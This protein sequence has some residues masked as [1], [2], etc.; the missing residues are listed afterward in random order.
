[1]REGSSEPLQPSPALH[2]RRRA[3]VDGDRSFQRRAL[4][5]DR[6]CVVAR[7]RLLLER[8]VVLFVDDDEPELANGREDRGARADHDAGL[9]ARDP[10]ALVP[11]LRVTERRVQDRDPVAEARG[12]PTHRLGREG[13]LGDEHDRTEAARER[14]GTGLEV[15]LRLAAPGRAVQQQ[16]IAPAGERCDDSSIASR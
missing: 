7:I 2:P 3:P 14:G 6:A 4:G 10:L 1:M 5:R 11:A 9:A 13:D 12:E 15:D 16:V 8:R